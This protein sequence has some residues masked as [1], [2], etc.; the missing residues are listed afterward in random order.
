MKRNGNLDWIRT[1]GPVQ[2]DV[3]PLPIQLLGGVVG[4][5]GGK[6]QHVALLQGDGEAAVEEE[7]GLVPE[8]EGPAGVDGR[9]VEEVHGEVDLVPC[10]LHAG[11]I[12]H[13]HVRGI[14]QWKKEWKNHGCTVVHWL[15]FLI[16]NQDLEG[17]QVQ[18]PPPHT[19]TL[20][21]EMEWDVAISWQLQD[22]VYV[23]ITG[24]RWL[25][26]ANLPVRV[27]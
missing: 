14:C 23:V 20:C 8:W 6:P 18:T 5:P 15:V 1:I 22:L 2:V 7:A 11:A 4:I 19:C 12:R 21:R 16:S 3:P 26:C 27:T 13:A 10:G 25:L 24:C 9:S 17:W